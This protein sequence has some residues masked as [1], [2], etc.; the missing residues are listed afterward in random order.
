VNITQEEKC[1]TVPV[2]AT[3]ACIGVKVECRFLLSLPI[4]RVKEFTNRPLS[5]P[6]KDMRYPFK[7]EMGGPRQIFWRFTRKGKTLRLPRIER[8]SIRSPNGILSYFDC[9]I[10]NSASKRRQYVSKSDV[11][12]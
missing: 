12:Y 4:D 2:Q 5:L 8:H 11:H 7:M 6:G 9:Y 3:N 1:Y 10:P